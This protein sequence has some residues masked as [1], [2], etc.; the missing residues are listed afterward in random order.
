MKSE[1][2]TN[3]GDNVIRND[4]ICKL[5]GRDDILLDISG[6]FSIVNIEVIKTIII[7]KV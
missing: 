6:L 2:M 1:F 5:K 3:S 7:V 4:E